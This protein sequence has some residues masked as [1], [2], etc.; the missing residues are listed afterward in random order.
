M[1]MLICG[2]DFDRES[3]KKSKIIEK[4]SESL[5]NIFDA[6]VI[7][8]GNLNLITNIDFSK[9]D[10]AL[11][12]PNIS[13]DEEKI[14]P[15]IKEINQKILLISTKRV[16]EKQYSDFDVVGH[17]LKNK[18]NLGIK[19]TKDENNRYV[20]KLIDPLGNEYYDGSDLNDLAAAIGKRVRFIKSLKR[21]KSQRVGD[22]REFKISEEFIEFIKHTGSEFTKYVNAVNPNRFLGNASTRCMFGF[23]AE[24]QDE[25][26][27]VTQRN[28]DKELIETNGFVE[29]T[30]N[31]EIVE[32]YGEKKPSVDTPIQIRLFDYYKNINFMVHG[33]V[34]IENA[35]MTESKIPC[36]FVEEFEEIIEM[37]PSR[38]ETSFA[39]NLKGHGCL[40]VGNKVEDLWKHSNFKSRDL[41][42]K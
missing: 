13:N 8:G 25:R 5:K 35:K 14:I 27:F 39:I 16:I 24:K 3:G 10:I 9:Y 7:N 12:C 21:I 11:W 31:T 17:L 42:E 22:K 32:Y 4:L 37:Y 2:G 1:K 23:P 15:N 36:G 29:V 26:L 30:T 40:I 19:I 41:T 6:D 38:E 20:F 18:S 34:Y 33:H 28:I